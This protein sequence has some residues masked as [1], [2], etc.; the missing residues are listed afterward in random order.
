MFWG[1]YSEREGQFMCSSFV[2]KLYEAAYMP[3]RVNLISFTD[4]GAA[5]IYEYFGAVLNT[6]YRNALN[7]QLNLLRVKK[8]QY[9]GKLPQKLS[10]G[11]VAVGKNTWILGILGD[12]ERE[13]EIA[14]KGCGRFRRREYHADQ[15]KNF[16][17]AALQMP[18]Y[19]RGRT[20]RYV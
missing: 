13:S 7:P 10:D 5:E 14:E 2:E 17:P 19:A 20:Q 9:N 18:A 6:L 16:C 3:E 12:S 15:G 8:G 4:M 11:S 1:Y